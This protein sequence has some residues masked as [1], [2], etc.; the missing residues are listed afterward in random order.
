M[1]AG[2]ITVNA[3]WATIECDD[4]MR[5]ITIGGQGG[6]L[7]NI[8]TARVYLGM[9]VESLARDDAQHDGEIYLDAGDSIPIPAQA[10]FVKHQC[11]TSATTKLWY[12]PRIA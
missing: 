10:S 7:V 8:G 6:S 3:R 12:I 2:D 1:A 5:T 9:D 11:A 4:T